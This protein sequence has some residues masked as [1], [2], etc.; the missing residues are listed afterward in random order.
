MSI[1][2]RTCLLLTNLLCYWKWSEWIVMNTHVLYFI[3]SPPWHIHLNYNARKGKKNFQGNFNNTCLRIINIFMLWCWVFAHH[4]Y[5]KQHV[6][7]TKVKLASLRKSF[8][9]GW[10][11]YHS[12]LFSTIY[13]L[14]NYHHLGKTSYDMYTCT[15]EIT[16]LFM[17]H[18]W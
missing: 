11:H 4:L 18:T 13:N 6:L 9:N 17:Y 3:F 2:V 5:L 7:W 16:N 1:C 8:H 10:F 14:C 15:N 12:C